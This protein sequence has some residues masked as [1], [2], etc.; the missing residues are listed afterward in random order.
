M[1]NENGQATALLETKRGPKLRG[2]WVDM[3]DKTRLRNITCLRNSRKHVALAAYAS[4]AYK[5]ASESHITQPM[6]LGG[7]FHLSNNFTV[8][9]GDRVPRSDRVEVTA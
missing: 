4:P 6:E 5:H 3:H 9:R 1:E 7:K 2:T 8:S